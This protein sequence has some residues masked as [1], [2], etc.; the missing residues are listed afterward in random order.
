[1]LNVGALIFEGSM[2]KN[3][4]AQDRYYAPVREELAS[5]IE[6]A[7]KAPAGISGHPVAAQHEARGAASAL[8]EA[9]LPDRLIEELSAAQEQMRAEPRLA[10]TKP[11]ATVVP[12]Q[13][14]R[15]IL[16]SWHSRYQALLAAVHRHIFDRRIEQSFQDG[17]PHSSLKPGD[18]QDRYRPH[19]RYRLGALGCP[20]SE[21]LRLCG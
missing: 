9:P 21:A 5:L 14:M 15:D 19:R 10:P 3:C 17:T 16:R 12:A 8:A 4:A 20:R 7:V 2:N 6:Q 18:G 13:G 1:M 11:A